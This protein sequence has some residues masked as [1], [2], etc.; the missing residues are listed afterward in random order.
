VAAPVLAAPLYLG[1]L[2]T[3]VSAS[4]EAAALATCS[5][6]CDAVGE[7]RVGSV[8]SEQVKRLLT[9]VEL[10]SKDTTTSSI[11]TCTCRGMTVRKSCSGCRSTRTM[12][13]SRALLPISWARSTATLRAGPAWRQLQP[14]L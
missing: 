4:V 12:L 8:T 11:G 1:D 9:Q 14:Q 5:S 7:R 13:C 3:M 10:F 6:F 2:A